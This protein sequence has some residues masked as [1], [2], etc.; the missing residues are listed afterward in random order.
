MATEIEMKL[1]VPDMET[2]ESVLADPELLQYAKD[3]FQIRQMRGVYYDTK[4]SQLHQRKWTLRLRDE[5]AIRI[6]A[7][8]TAGIDNAAGFFTRNEWQVAVE[9]IEDAIP[10]LIE[11]GAP[12]EL[13]SILKGR[14]LEPVC[15]ADFQRRSV[16]LYLE[17]GVRIEMAGDSGDLFAGERKMSFCE[18]ELELLYGDAAS[19]LPLC[20]Q[21]MTDYGL[22]EERRSKYSRARSLIGND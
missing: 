13:R 9:R 15:G 11:Q 22:E 10:L 7:M 2:M 12:R 18:L 17:D 19:L 6:A 5:G 14:K 3:E 20:Q 8:K 1:A 16:C 21:L 4:D